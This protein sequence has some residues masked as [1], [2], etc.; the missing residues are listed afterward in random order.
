MSEQTIRDGRALSWTERFAYAIGNFGAGLL[1]TVIGSWAMYFYAPPPDDPELEPYIPLAMVGLV[2]F[3][4]R[5]AEALVNPFIGFWSD[6]VNTKHGR[7]IPF[8]MY[9]TPAMVAA[10][11]LMW[12]PP[13]PHESIINAIY[14]AFLSVVVG[15][16]FA[17]VAAP[18]LSLLPELT[19]YN[20]ERI[21]VSALMAVFE[22]FGVLI[23]AAGAGV[24]INHFKAGNGIL[25]LDGFKMVGITVGVLTLAAYMT[26]VIF[27][28]ERPYSEAKDV[29]FDFLQSV[30][31]SFAN[32]AFIPYLVAVTTLR[33]ALDTVIV[34]IPYIVTT[35]MGGTETTASLLQAGIL[36]VAML[37]F[38]VVNALSNKLGK[39]KVFFW[40]TFGFV[41]ILPLVATVGKWP[42]LSPLWQGVIVFMAAALPVAT[43]SVLQRPLMADII[44]HDEKLTG[45]R[46]EAMYNGMEGLFSRTASGLAWVL[47]SLLFFAFGNSTEQPLGILLCGPVAGAI[48][49]VG[50]YFFRR[51]PFER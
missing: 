34:V 20:N 41:I 40:G 22:I 13:V 26:T 12:F 16:S 7:R 1:P 27:I 11:I 9:G 17:A 43:I 19:P 37:L 30:K 42:I 31:S 46:R 18:Y 8:L 51:Y 35:V 33:L 38:P 4:G 47:A 2:L 14:V 39:K 5:F 3:V 10:F 25:G 36:V 29:K 32:P 23:A 21:T 49:A 48:M 28:K 15:V 45:F 6:R 50:L 44:D 24:V